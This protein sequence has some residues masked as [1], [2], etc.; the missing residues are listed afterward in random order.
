[1]STDG[2]QL[3]LP[4]GKKST[5]HVQDIAG[6][7]GVRKV[8]NHHRG[9]PRGKCLRETAFFR[10]YR[11]LK[12]VP[13]LLEVANPTH[14]LMDLVPGEPLSACHKAMSSAEIAALSAEHGKCIG[15]FICHESTP[16]AWERV[17]SNYPDGRDLAA[18][19]ERAQATVLDAFQHNPTFDIP[20][21]QRA[22]AQAAKVVLI[23]G[24]WGR[25]A[26]CKLDWNAGNMLV[27]DGRISGYVDFEQSF[28]GNRLAFVGTVIDHI[29][30]LNWHEARRG[31]EGR[32][33]PLPSSEM[34]YAAACF[35]MCVKISEC[36]HGGKISFFT[37]E[38][39]LVKFRDMK[40]MITDAEPGVQ[41]DGAERRNLT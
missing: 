22:I 26:L 33:G 2:P 4:Q 36:C 38:R 20:A 34:Q 6:R 12:A 10:H 24:D 9:S 1:M 13:N 18:V 17:R 8:Y 19:L 35:S 37:P 25:E 23:E 15:D 41:A 5:V 27:L 28:V 16:A 29:N 39:L 7:P 14:I 40:K 31:I 21:L 30:V 3:T 11:G 32:C